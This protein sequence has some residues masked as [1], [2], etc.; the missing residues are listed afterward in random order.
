LF[1][2]IRRQ[3]TILM[4]NPSSARKSS[5]S[6]PI[7]VLEIFILSCFLY[8][9][10]FDQQWWGGRGTSYWRGSSDKHVTYCTCFRHASWRRRKLASSTKRRHHYS[11]IEPPCSFTKKDKGWKNCW[12]C[13]SDGQF[14]DSALRWCKLVDLYIFLILFFCFFFTPSL[15]FMPM[16]LLLCSPWIAHD[17]RASPHRLPIY[18]VP[19]IC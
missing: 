9:R 19:W 7:L 15:F 11:S 1:L 3:L 5:L 2:P 8:C 18:W 6:L 17:Q 16:F 10:F 12:T 13:P 4:L 14:V